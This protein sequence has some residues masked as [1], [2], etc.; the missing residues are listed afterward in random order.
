MALPQALLL[1]WLLHRQL[2]PAEQH[3]PSHNGV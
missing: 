2:A 3:H 1:L